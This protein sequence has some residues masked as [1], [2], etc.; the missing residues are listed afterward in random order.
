ML[1]RKIVE[2]YNVDED[3]DQA[4]WKIKD[5]GDDTN[6]GEDH[7]DDARPPFS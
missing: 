4:S 3:A 6:H 1:S 2:D 5:P 7:R